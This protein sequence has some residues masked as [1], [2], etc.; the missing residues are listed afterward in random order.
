[1][2]D[3]AKHPDGYEVRIEPPR[4]DRADFMDC[5]FVGTVSSAKF[6]RLAQ[7][8]DGGPR[9]NTF[10]GN[11]FSRARLRRVE[12][13]GGIDL[14]TCRLPEGLEY[15]HIE[16]FP[17]KAEQARVALASWPDGERERAE[18]LLRL[19]ERDGVDTLFRWRGS[20]AGA[21]SA[22][23]PLLESLERRRRDPGTTP[24]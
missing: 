1:M 10:T 17:A 2:I 24:A 7:H 21:D 14:G 13:R 3:W 9:H 12:F 6:Y 18:S 20:L 15:I 8:A 22:L 19:Y 16:D 5:T 23:W 4:E 11:D